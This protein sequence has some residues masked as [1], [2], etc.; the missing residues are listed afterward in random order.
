MKSGGYISCLKDALTVG[1]GE[2][3]NSGIALT[4]GRHRLVE[5]DHYPWIEES[6]RSYK[7]L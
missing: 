5:V 7:W 6:A 2:A 4:A 3:D 1:D